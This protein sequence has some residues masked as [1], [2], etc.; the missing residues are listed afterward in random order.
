MLCYDI[1]YTV[2]YFQK[3]ACNCNVFGKQSEITS[4]AK[5]EISSNFKFRL[6]V[7]DIPHVHT[8]FQ[9]KKKLIL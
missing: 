3:W 6:K 1:S 2:L 4:F 5:K 7:S 8:Y 9:H